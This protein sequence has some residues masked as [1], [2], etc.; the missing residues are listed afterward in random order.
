MYKLMFTV[1]LRY[2]SILYSRPSTVPQW[3]FE[4]WNRVT[5]GSYRWYSLFCYAHK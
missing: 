1:S 5:I 3:G 2:R 4:F